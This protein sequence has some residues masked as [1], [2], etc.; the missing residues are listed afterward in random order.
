MLIESMLQGKSLLEINNHAKIESFVVLQTRG[1]TQQSRKFWQKACFAETEKGG[2]GI[3]QK[4]YK[5]WQA[6]IDNEPRRLG[7]ESASFG[8]QFGSQRYA[9]LY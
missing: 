9:F 7:F 5:E 3:A 6:G 2:E 4:M 1:K 8:S